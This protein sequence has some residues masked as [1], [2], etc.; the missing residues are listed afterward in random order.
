MA[1]P[2][3]SNITT[4]QVTVNLSQTAV[5]FL[6]QNSK[7][8]DYAATLGGWASY[9]TDTQA[10]GGILLEPDQHDYLSSLNEGKRFRDGKALVRAVEKGLHRENAQYTF[11]VPVDPAHYPALRENAEAGGLTVEESLEGILQMIFASSWIYDFTPTQGRSIPFT[12]EMLKA[13]KDVCEKNR[14]DSADITGLIAENRF[15]PITRETA[16]RAKALTG[17]AEFTPQDIDALLEKLENLLAGKSR[18][19]TNANQLVEVA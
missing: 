6:R 11:T 13:V 10:R 18:A 15:V 7:D 17:K 3:Q 14:I 19:S 8:G 16:K 1:A 12:Y 2:K 4:L 9:W 5:N